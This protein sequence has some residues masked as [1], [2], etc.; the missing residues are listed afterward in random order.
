M[1]DPEFQAYVEPPNVAAIMN[2]TNKAPLSVAPIQSISASFWVKVRSGLGF[3][4][5]VAN[6]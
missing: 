4:D 3:R 6:K 1:D 5:G 2:K